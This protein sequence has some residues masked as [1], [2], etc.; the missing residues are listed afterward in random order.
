[1]NLHILDPHPDNIPPLLD[2]KRVGKML[3]E[4]NQMLSLAVKLGDDPMARPV[5]PADIGPGKLTDGLAHAN[6][7]VSQWVRFT[8]SNFVWTAQYASALAAEFKFRFGKDHLSAA[9]TNFI[10]HRYANNIQP[11]PLTPFQNSARNSQR[12]VEFSAL[13][14]FEAYRNYMIYR[15]N[16]D[17]IECRWTNRGMPDFL[18]EYNMKIPANPRVGIWGNFGFQRSFHPLGHWVGSQLPDQLVGSYI[19]QELDEGT[20]R[21]Q[22]NVLYD[23]SK[24]KRERLETVLTV[25]SNLQ[26]LIDAMWLYDSWEKVENGRL[27]E[28]I[29]SVGRVDRGVSEPW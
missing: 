4:A 22:V 15:W 27:P 5:D 8:Y 19:E 24:P 11:G 6:H 14:I 20:L 3:M 23:P 17:R 29:G 13:N 12:D 18:R 21:I 26:P 2:D 25:N 9:R 1:L 10:M 7:P 28:D 16:T